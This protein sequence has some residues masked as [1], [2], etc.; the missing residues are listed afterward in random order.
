MT[1]RY[2]SLLLRKNKHEYNLNSTYHFILRQAHLNYFVLPFTFLRILHIL[3]QRIALLLSAY[4]LT[5][6]ELN[7]C[8]IVPVVRQHRGG[9]ITGCV[10]EV[11]TNQQLQ[12]GEH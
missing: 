8:I 4:E 7:K 12:S 6:I 2:I 5:N 9:T 3:C 1:F 10:Q 11:T